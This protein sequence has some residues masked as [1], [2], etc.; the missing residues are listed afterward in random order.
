MNRNKLSTR[1]AMAFACLLGLAG[2]AHAEPTED[3]LTVASG[4]NAFAVDLY[5]RLRTGT[6]GNLF[7]SPHSIS[8][9]LAMTYAGAEG[10]TAK[11]MAGVLQFALPEAKLHPAFRAW[12]TDLENKEETPG[13]QLRVANRL[14]GQQGAHFL[15]EFLEVTRFEYGAELGRLDFKRGEAARNTINAWIE[16][17]TDR[18]IR[19]LIA[20]GTLPADTKLV[21]TNA[22]YLKAPWTNDFDKDATVNAPFHV[23]KSKRITVPTMRQTSRFNYVEMD[24]VKVLEMPY[25]PRRNLSMLFV[26]PNK[27]DGLGEV[28]KQL[29]TGKLQAW[30]EAMDSELVH[31]Y[32]PKFKFTS[33]FNLRNVLQ[34]MG[35][36]LIFSDGADFSRMSSQDPLTIGAVI[37]QAYVEVNEV[38]TE[39]A[40][41]TAISMIVGSA[42]PGFDPP[43]VEFR[44][45]HPFLFLVRDNRTKGMLFMGRVMNPKE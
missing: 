13:I 37:H 10:E 36:A 44:A 42:P 16:E 8:S 2:T 11:Q 39:A 14:W 28:E 34:S 7:F 6:S 29:T 32:L 35:M 40:A 15:P 17:Q 27:L 26:L 30:T 41:A 38:G 19:N 3:V 4:G 21:L 22:I 12:R 45:D 9:A 33:G 25:G 5:G 24:G 20:P 23:S 1:A 18:K 31:V 43:P